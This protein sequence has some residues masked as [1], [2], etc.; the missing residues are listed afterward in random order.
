MREI[1]NDIKKYSK[2]IWAMSFIRF[3]ITGVFNTIIGTTVMFIC[4]NWLNLG[5]WISSAM[6]YIIGSIFSY[7]ANKYFTFRSN[8]KSWQEII[9]FVLNISLCYITAYGVAIRV[10]QYF[11]VQ[12][13]EL[14]M[15]N[16]MVEQIA[17]VNGMVL[18]VILNYLGQKI[19]VFK[20]KG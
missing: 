19:F 1:V 12:I 13:I 5:Y 11:I 9:R 7:F 17:M 20:N 4:Y 18:F 3:A 15:E 10:V 6:N 14:N 16:A 8:S 2:K